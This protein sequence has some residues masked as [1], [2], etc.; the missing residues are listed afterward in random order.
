ML[1]V[2]L[3][4]PPDAMHTEFTGFSEL[5]PPAPVTAS[6][7]YGEGAGCAMEAECAAGETRLTAFVECGE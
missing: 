2:L 4:T 7:F 3:P 6:K 5:E 1:G